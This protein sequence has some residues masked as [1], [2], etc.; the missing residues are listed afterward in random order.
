MIMKAIFSM[1]VEGNEVW[2]KSQDTLTQNVHMALP[3]EIQE[4]DETSGG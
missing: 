2:I 4:K 3:A 1:L